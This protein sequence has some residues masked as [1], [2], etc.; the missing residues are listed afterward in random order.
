M[1]N[2][3]AAASQIWNVVTTTWDCDPTLKSRVIAFSGSILNKNV[4]YIL[5]RK[6]KGGVNVSMENVSVSDHSTKRTA[7]HY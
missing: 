2:L 5:R 4:R 7:G 3:T 6:K 1:S